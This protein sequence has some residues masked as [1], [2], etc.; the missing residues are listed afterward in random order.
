KGEVFPDAE[1]VSDPPTFVVVQKKKMRILLFAGGPSR[2]YQFL[3]RILYS[4][5]QEKRMEL[6]IYL[7][8]GDPKESD[9]DVEQEWLLTQFPDKIGVEDKSHLTFNEYDVIIAVDPDWTQLTP[10]QLK[11][12]STWVD[13]HAGGVIFVAGPVHT[14]HL[15]RPGGFDLSNLINIF[16]VRLKDSRLH[17]VGIGHNPQKKYYLTFTEFA[18]LVGFLKL[19][20]QQGDNPTAA[21]DR[22][23]WADRPRPEPGKEAEPVRGFHN[24]YPVDSLKA[25]SKV[26]ASF[27]GGGGAPLQRG[28][29]PPPRTPPMPRVHGQTQSNPPPPHPALS[30]PPP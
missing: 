9:Q 12:L 17:G 21:W 8:T 18:K 3:R 14:F 16:P 28:R 22:F 11:L 5:V 24:F 20:E 27:I 6:A 7:Q 19:D 15:A 26:I 1:H 30:P 4:E 10:D 25:D 29:H 23:F 2:E 13:A